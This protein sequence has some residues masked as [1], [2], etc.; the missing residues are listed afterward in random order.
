MNY[1]SFVW[2]MEM[3]YGQDMKRMTLAIPIENSDELFHNTGS[4]DKSEQKTGMC[5][6][7]WSNDL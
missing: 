4:E 6:E 5:L 1:M 2:N 7:E 3:F